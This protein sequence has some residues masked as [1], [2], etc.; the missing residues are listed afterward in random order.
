MQQG[1]NRDTS[2][3]LMDR[4][5]PGRVG[6]VLPELDVPFQQLPDDAM[7]RTEL[8]KAQGYIEKTEAAEDDHE[9]DLPPRDLRMETPSSSHDTLMMCS[10]TPTHPFALWSLGLSSFMWSPGWVRGQRIRR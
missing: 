10:K 3:L 1:G 9:K 2:K 7:L 6:S 5:V 8:T 4:S